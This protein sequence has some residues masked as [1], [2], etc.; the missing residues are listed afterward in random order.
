M[1]R[2]YKRKKR[3][4]AVILG[5][6]RKP[7]PV[8]KGGIFNPE[9]NEVVNKLKEAL[10]E[11]Q[12]YEFVYFDNH[13]TLK[14]DLKK[15]KKRGIDYAFNLCDEGF[16]NNPS[17]EKDIPRML[18]KLGIL[19]TGA[20]A[21]CM[22]LC[23]DK[24]RV[25]KLAEKIGIPIPK[26]YSLSQNLESKL[27]FPLIVKPNYGDGGFGVTKKSVVNSKDE[28]KDAL[29]I[30]RKESSY[31]KEII[32]E[33]FLLGD[34]ISVGIIGNPP[35]SYRVLPLAQ[36][37]YSELPEDLPRICGREA[38][39]EPDS[40]YWKYL[41]SLPAQLTKKTE[42]IIVRGSLKLFQTLD[43]RDYAR[44]DW[45]FNSSREP[46]LL[47]VNPN[48]GWCWDGHMAKMALLDN[49]SYPKMLEMILTEAEK[50]FNF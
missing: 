14:S 46:K 33:E 50:R 45:R 19:Y 1:K 5:D 42:R 47:E 40:P 43:C 9:D 27:E 38:K 15:L 48:P 18:E 30:L 25:K 29:S 10:K 21:E 39:W 31:K 41:K 32:L 17:R 4:V 12:G 6:P 23:Y 11:L 3:N 2:L 35:R 7:D 16:F 37:D 20:G 34:E 13:E 49:I 26:S 36:E 44:F 24:L 8:K 22:I 28:L